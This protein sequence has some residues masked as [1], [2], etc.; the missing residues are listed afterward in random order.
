MEELFN[1]LILRLKDQ[2]ALEFKNIFIDGTKIEIDSIT[3]EIPTD[4]VTA[5][6]A[7]GILRKL[8]E[9]KENENIVFVYGKGKR[10]SYLQ[11]HIKG[12]EN[13]IEK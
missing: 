12:I 1:E 2:N 10:K 11:K 7:K 3:I 6:Y 5:E 4:K 13:F 8:D 9:I